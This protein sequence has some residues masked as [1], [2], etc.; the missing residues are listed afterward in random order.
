MR[1]RNLKQ[2]FSCAWA[3]IVCAFSTQRN[4]KIHGLA[5]LLVI[6]FGLALRVSRL[7]WAVL[8]FA[9]FLVIVSEMINTAVEKTVDLYTR[10]YH[11]LAGMA[12]NVAAGAVLVACLG[13]V[14]TGII[15]FGPR[16]LEL[17]V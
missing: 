12:K 4:M 17:L 6:A 5:A 3:G 13:A 2:S 16:I 15:V 10:E 1:A 11:P 7:E 8:F 14:I 9:I